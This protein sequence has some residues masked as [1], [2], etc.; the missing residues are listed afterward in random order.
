METDDGYASGSSIPHQGLL[1]L[2]HHTIALPAEGSPHHRN[3]RKSEAQS[4]FSGSLEALL[5]YDPPKPE[6]TGSARSAVH[7]MQREMQPPAEAYHIRQKNHHRRFP[8]NL[9]SVLPPVLSPLANRKSHHNSSGTSHIR[10]ALH[11]VWFPS[12]TGSSLPIPVPNLPALSLHFGYFHEP[13]E[14]TVCRLSVPGKHR[15]RLSS[16]ICIALFSPPVW[17]QFFQR[18]GFSGLV[19]HHDLHV[20]IFFV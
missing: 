16:R 14:T 8:D 20:F 3:H 9:H 12:A 2:P 7:S 13:P 18:H 5:P 15:F 19:I 1:D 10:P 17:H 11:F 6:S 4:P